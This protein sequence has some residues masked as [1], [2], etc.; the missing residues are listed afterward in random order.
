MIS[1][2]KYNWCLF[3]DIYKFITANEKKLIINIIQKHKQKVNSN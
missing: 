1:I 3:K 2:P